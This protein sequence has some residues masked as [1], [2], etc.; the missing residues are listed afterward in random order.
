MDLMFRACI[1]N[2]ILSLYWFPAA[3]QLLYL[4]NTLAAEFGA[5]QAGLWKQTY[6]CMLQ[7]QC[8]G[9]DEDERVWHS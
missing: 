9:W 8:P 7:L 3:L 1:W 6:G 5:F 2:L 4:Q